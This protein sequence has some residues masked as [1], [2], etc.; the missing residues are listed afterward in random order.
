METR[1][2]KVGDAV[3][4]LDTVPQG[5]KVFLVPEMIELGGKTTEIIDAERNLNARGGFLYRLAADPN[6][7]WEC[8]MFVPV[9]NF[10]LNPD[11]D[12]NDIQFTSFESFIDA[13]KAPTI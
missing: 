4:I 5:D 3:R 2:Y 7:Y 9:F 1:R 6:W 8:H 10:E 13:F 12:E 11:D